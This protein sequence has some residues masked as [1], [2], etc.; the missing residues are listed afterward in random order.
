MKA[1]Q[2]VEIYQSQDRIDLLHADFFSLRKIKGDVVFLA[3]AF[4]KLDYSNFSIKKHLQ[5]NLSR[6][7]SQSLNMADSLCVMLPP[8]TDLEEVAA[9]FCDIF[10]E[11][12]E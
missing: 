8:I 7:I 1:K 5:P 10:N 12:P 11:N 3:P 9:L 6:L 4:N 2:I